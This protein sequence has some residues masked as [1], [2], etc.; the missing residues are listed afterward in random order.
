MIGNIIRYTTGLSS[1]LNVKIQ[2]YVN[3]PI[4]HVVHYLS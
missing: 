3:Y 1:T 4:G 2:L